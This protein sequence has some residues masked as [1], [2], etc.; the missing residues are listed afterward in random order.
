MLPATEKLRAWFLAT[1]C[2]FRRPRARSMLFS[3]SYN[4][5]LSLHSIRSRYIQWCQSHTRNCIQLTKERVV[6]ICRPGMNEHKMLMTKSKFRFS[7]SN[8][9]FQQFYGRYNILKNSTLTQS[10]T[11]R[12]YAWQTSI[13]RPCSLPM[14]LYLENSSMCFSYTYLCRRDTTSSWCHRLRPCGDLHVHG[15]FGS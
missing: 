5:S 13:L 7:F 12:N 2:L 10:S 4:A 3:A 15:S 6:Q 8:N 14:Q 1:C 9:R 11:T